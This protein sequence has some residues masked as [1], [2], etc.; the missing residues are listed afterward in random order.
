MFVSSQYILYLLLFKIHSN[1]LN[2][3][4]EAVELLWSTIGQIWIPDAQPTLKVHFLFE[5]ICV[6]Q[7]LIRTYL[8]LF[9]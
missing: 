4:S 2:V 6:M 7:N 9:S 5:S 8:K 1:Q 3:F